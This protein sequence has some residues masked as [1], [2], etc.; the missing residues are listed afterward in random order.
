MIMIYNFIKLKFYLD[1]KKNNL[2]IAIFLKK[3]E[4]NQHIRF[5]SQFI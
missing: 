2:Y 5:Y 4:D 3:K 1:S